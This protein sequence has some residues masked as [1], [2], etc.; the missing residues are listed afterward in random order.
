[1]KEKTEVSETGF[2]VLPIYDKGEYTI[3]VAAPA[4][5]SFHPEEISL[6]FD[7]VNDICSQ[8]KDVNFMFKGFGIH[9]KINIFNE[10]SAGAKGVLVKL[11][12]DKNSKITS[13]LTDDNGVFTFS[14]IVPGSYKVVASHDSWHLSKSE[15]S[16]KVS[17][18]NT[19][20]PK[21]ALLVS[22]F[23]LIGHMNHPPSK[24]GFLVYSAK[25]QQ[26]L[27]KCS[28][29]IPANVAQTISG[30]FESSPLCF[31]S[32]VKNGEF[33]FRNLASGRYLIVPFVD[34][35]DI[36]LHISPASIEAEIERD[37]WQIS[38]SFEVSGFSASGRILLSQQSTKGIS[39]AT[40]KLNG[41]V[42]ATTDASG[43]YTLKNIKDGTHTIQV[44]ATDLQFSDESVKISMSSPRVPDIFVSGFKVCGKVVS[45]QS[46]KVAIKKL[47]STFFTQVA[48]DPKD[49]GN[50]CAFLGNGK[51]SV[52]VLIDESERK[53]V[54]F[55]PLQHISEVNSEGVSDIIFSQL[56]AEVTGEVSCLPDE[57]CKIEVTL[58]ALDE[59]LSLKTKVINGVYSFQEILPGRYQ[60][61]VP[62]ENICWAQNQ[63]NIVIK[64]ALEKVPIFTQSGFKLA[65]IVASH[66]TQVNMH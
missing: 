62:S 24:I 12:S 36:E 44:T 34:K 37:N 20:L 5:Y 65:P 58:S 25:K 54:Q 57:P 30:D 61:T 59:T 51:Y 29:K 11:Y 13:A 14:P 7:G 64:T 9:G 53:N 31:T 41:K 47:G 6:D 56:R 1:M 45:E 3:R 28:E 43:A 18:G 39:G 17:T 27:H 60:V 15:F 52:E 49:G 10:P 50:F 22:G 32:Q 40:V 63:Q 33:S 2:F 66:D 55:Y 4:G 46:F 35:N 19:E 48:S 16:V 26:N 8:K 21:E 38:E 23:N 42:V